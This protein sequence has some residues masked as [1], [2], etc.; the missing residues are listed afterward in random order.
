MLFRSIGPDES[1]LDALHRG[2]DVPGGA[3][4]G[5]L[6]AEHIPRLDRAAQF[7]L[8]AVEDRG[9]DPREPELGERDRK[10]VVWGKSVPV[11]VELGGSRIIN[12]KTRSDIK[13]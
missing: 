3:G 2:I 13:L 12:K 8:D 11:G 9:A 7:D 10:S 4:S 5:G 1:H 6:I